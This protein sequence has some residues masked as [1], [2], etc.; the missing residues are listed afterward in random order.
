[1]LSKTKVKVRARKK[2][3]P[4]LTG[5]IVLCIK[6]KG[7]ET[8][9]KILS[10][11]TRKFSSVNLKRIEEN[12]KVGDTIAIPGKVLSQGDLT[13]KIRICALGISQSAKEKLKNSKSEFV[14]LGDEVKSNKKAEGVKI[15]R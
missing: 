11:S 6:N 2:T 10:S 15:I 3:N 7:W 12:S 1:M 5:L 9:A 8:I 13:K 14:F 4:A